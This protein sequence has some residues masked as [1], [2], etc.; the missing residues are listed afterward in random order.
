MRLSLGVITVLATFYLSCGSSQNQC[1]SNITPS[2]SLPKRASWEGIW[3]TNY[4]QMA[5]TTKG[6][7]LVGEYCSDEAKQ[8]GKIEGTI[9]GDV[10][11]FRWIAHDLRVEGKER[12]TQGYGILQYKIEG[13][14]K[15]ETH[16]FTGTWGY[17]N[18]ECG[19]GIWKG[20]KSKRFSE[21]YRL[22]R[23]QIPC[24]LK[25]GEGTAD[26]FSEK[27]EA[28]EEITTKPSSHEG[29]EMEEL[30]L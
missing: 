7:F 16:K 1:K 8:W 25:G 17:E 9:T 27:E 4:G 6:N 15:N 30:G 26:D 29:E 22:G 14:G 5:I 19:G 18:S 11:R 21:L 24:E 12:I 2:G 3:F 23:Y 13:E 20:E 10:V 28:E